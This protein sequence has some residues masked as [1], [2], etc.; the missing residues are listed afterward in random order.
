MPGNSAVAVC[1]FVAVALF[2]T[3]HASVVLFN[4]CV[5]DSDCSFMN[6]ECFDSR[7]NDVA[8][9]CSC[10]RGMTFDSAR[11][12]CEPV[13]FATAAGRSD[14]V[15]LD[16]G[17]RPV[18]Y[19]EQRDEVGMV[20]ARAVFPSLWH[21]DALNSFCWAEDDA[22][23]YTTL[24][25]SSLHPMKTLASFIELRYRNVVWK[26]RGEGAI[27]YRRND[28]S[29]SD[30]DRGNA[31]RPAPE[32]CVTHSMICGSQRTGTVG[33]GT[34]CECSDP[35]TGPTCQSRMALDIS[36]PL[37]ASRQCSFPSNAGCAPNEIC[38]RWHQP[39]VAQSG[40]WCW[41]GPGYLPAAILSESTSPDACILTTTE[42]MYG[43]PAIPYTADS[44]SYAVTVDKATRQYFHYTGGGYR[45]ASVAPYAPAPD[46][47]LYRI[48][49][50]MFGLV[51]SY[52]WRCD[53]AKSAWNGTACV[54][55]QPLAVAIPAQQS[56]S[57]SYA[58]CPS[59]TQYGPDCAWNA[60]VCAVQRC[61]AHGQCVG[62]HQGCQCG[63]GWGGYNCSTRACFP[64]AASPADPHVY[65]PSAGSCN[66]SHLHQGTWCE[67]F[68]CG[69]A[70]ATIDPFT[71]ACECRGRWTADGD[72]S[73]TAHTCGAGLAP[74]RVDAT[75]CEA[76]PNYIREPDEVHDGVLSPD[77]PPSPPRPALPDDDFGWDPPAR[78]LSTDAIAAIGSQAAVVLIAV[79]SFVMIIAA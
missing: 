9:V 32:N 29:S 53:E 63:M 14:V 79:S 31:M 26:C 51:G 43:I 39:G 22:V 48:N 59:P 55:E 64:N 69:N 67:R 16:Y 62:T 44:P 7:G 3:A 30:P 25:I 27:F 2:W 38:Y 40:S 17:I 8:R 74:S 4:A 5:S 35:F 49:D 76:D 58:D 33:S 23:Y 50:T 73:C 66:C 75:I 13:A 11:A 78:S 12:V 77:S 20:R 57:V 60:T 10:A 54:L 24:E 18:F 41:C 37:V 52:L 6:G 72:G 28:A 34:Q 36:R 46:N 1:L 70:A 21:C 19:T 68:V 42:T 65:S 61:S 15:E 47:T 45:Y 71:L 56:A